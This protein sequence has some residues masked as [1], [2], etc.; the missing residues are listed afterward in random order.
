LDYPPS[1]GSISQFRRSRTI[2]ISCHTG[3]DSYIVALCG[4]HL[5]QSSRDN[6]FIGDRGAHGGIV[7][8]CNYS[9]C[10]IYRHDYIFRFHRAQLFPPL[11]YERAA[12]I[13]RINRIVI[14]I[15]VAKLGRP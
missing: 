15:G 1:V 12:R 4:A 14:V 3:I 5:S 6:I 13:N 7:V 11:A 10:V 9:R 8:V 2:A